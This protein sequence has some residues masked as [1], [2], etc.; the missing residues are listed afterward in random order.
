L[1]QTRFQK[2]NLKR[3]VCNCIDQLSACMKCGMSQH[4]P[5]YHAIRSSFTPRPTGLIRFGHMELCSM[6]KSH[7]LNNG[8]PWRG[9]P[10]YFT[11]LMA[12][13]LLMGGDLACRDRGLTA[14]IHSGGTLSA[15]CAETSAASRSARGGKSRSS[16]S[17]S[18]RPAPAAD[19]AGVSSRLPCRLRRHEAGHRPYIS[20][21]VL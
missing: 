12:H 20:L 10:Q 15:F 17:E 1:F 2:T 13:H 16:G 9:T 11:Q 4:T 7:E 6:P 14:W 5:V 21:S 8:S 18:G 19:T 3:G